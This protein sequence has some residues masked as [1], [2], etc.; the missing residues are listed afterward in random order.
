MPTP[1][2]VHLHYVLVSLLVTQ[3]MEASSGRLSAKE[4]NSQEILI[5]RMFREHTQIV[6]HGE[7]LSCMGFFFSFEVR[8]NIIMLCVLS[9][10]V[11]QLS[12]A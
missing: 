10:N 11:R 3:E 6:G 5:F 4:Q 9:W 12:D 7:I 1:G 2:C 8:W